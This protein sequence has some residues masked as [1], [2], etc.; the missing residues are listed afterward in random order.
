MLGVVVMC[1][2]L[3]F[4]KSRRLPLLTHNVLNA[5]G[6][7]GVV[8]VLVEQRGVTSWSHNHLDR[9]HSHVDRPQSNPSTIP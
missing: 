3:H 4:G 1:K 7:P 8:A 6:K 5:F 9:F 2:G